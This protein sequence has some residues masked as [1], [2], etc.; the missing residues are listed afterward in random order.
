MDEPQS[1]RLVLVV[2]DE[3]DMR[4]M[5]GFVLPHYGFDVRTANGGNEA[6]RVVQT[7]R[8]DLVLTD[9]R[10]PGMDGFATTSALKQ[11]V[12][13]LPVVIASGY[14]PGETDDHRT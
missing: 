5:L 12:P 14:A 1:R 3:P 6:I 4:E 2:D 8:F 11:I 7:T 10:M 9:L 13:E